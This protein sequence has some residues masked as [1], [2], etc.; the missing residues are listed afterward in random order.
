M[1]RTLQNFMYTML[2]DD[3]SIAPR[4]SLGVMIELYRKGVWKDEKTVNV[5]A[6][7]AFHKDS[8]VIGIAYLNTVL[9]LLS[10]NIFQP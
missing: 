7:G 8:K 2:E 3:S 1:N 10:W 5:I 6:T 9:I 4:E